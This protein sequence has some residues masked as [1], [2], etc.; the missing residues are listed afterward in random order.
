MMKAYVIKIK[1]FED[2]AISDSSCFLLICAFL[3]FT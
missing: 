3:L 2:K 1:Q